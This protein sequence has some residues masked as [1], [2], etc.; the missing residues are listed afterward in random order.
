LK[1]LH[2]VV[3]P[4]RR[5]GAVKALVVLHTCYNVVDVVIRSLFVL[6]WTVDSTRPS[7]ATP[8]LPPPR[9]LFTMASDTSRL[10]SLERRQGYQ[11]QNLSDGGLIDY[12][13]YA[14]RVWPCT[15]D[16]GTCS[17]R[18]IPVSDLTVPL[19]LK[20]DFGGVRSVFCGNLRGPRARHHLRGCHVGNCRRASPDLHRWAALL[21][22]ASRIRASNQEGFLRRRSTET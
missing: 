1:W 3:S 6:L 12:W 18:A 11:S 8:R 15:N 10:A 4:P 14:V 17:K 9:H 20:T 7:I 16:E 2:A 13:G 21:G 22:S 19:D 5:P